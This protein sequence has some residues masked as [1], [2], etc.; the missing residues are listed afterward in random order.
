MWHLVV[1]LRDA[2]RKGRTKKAGDCE[3][4]GCGRGAKGVGWLEQ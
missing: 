4:A 3:M 1:L 2:R